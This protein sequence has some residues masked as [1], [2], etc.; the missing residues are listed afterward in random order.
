MKASGVVAVAL[1]AALSTGCASRFR[2]AVARPAAGDEPRRAPAGA[3]AR[4][5]VAKLPTDLA[6]LQVMLGQGIEPQGFD[7][8]A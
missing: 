1:A 8:L 4:L 5:T 3:S 6:W 2:A 7:P